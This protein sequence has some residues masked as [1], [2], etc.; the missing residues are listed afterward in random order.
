MNTATA[1]IIR[2]TCDFDAIASSINDET[3]NR[4][5]THGDA[6]VLVKALAAA[7][8]ESPEWVEEFASAILR[9]RKELK[10]GPDAAGARDRAAQ[11]GHHGQAG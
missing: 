5:K 7:D 2:Q 10:D 8:D 6:V 11:E 4:V 3:I 9:R 1:R